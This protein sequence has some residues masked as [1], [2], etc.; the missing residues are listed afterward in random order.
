MDVFDLAD[1]MPSEFKGI[2]QERETTRSPRLM[3]SLQGKKLS[4]Y[5]IRRFY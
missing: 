5:T 1:R 4:I 3:L 2:C